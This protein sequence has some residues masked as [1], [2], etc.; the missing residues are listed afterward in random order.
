MQ[1]P[2][3][4]R[5]TYAVGLVMLLA[6]VASA[7]IP[8]IRRQATQN[9]S[10]EPTSA[11]TATPLPV[12]DVSAITFDT[13]Y[14]HP[15]GLF[16]V[17]EPS[18]WNPGPGTNNGVQEQV[19]MNNPDLESIVEAYVE[20][21]QTPLT[22][23][24]ELSS[25]FDSTFLDRSWSRYSDWKETGRKE[26]GDKLVIDFE[27]TSGPRS[28][29]ARHTAWT[30][31]KWI[32]AVRVVMPE[33]GRDALL[34]LLDK[35]IPTLQPIRKFEGTPIEWNAYFDNE[36]K[37]IIRYP[38]EWDILD[39]AQGLPASLGQGTTSLRLESDQGAVADEAAAQAWV[40]GQYGGA[41]VLSVEP[42]ERDGNKGFS[43][44][45]DYTDP[46]GE[47]MSGL[48]VLLNGPD[49]RLHVANLRFMAKGVDLNNLG[50]QPV[51]Q[52]ATL[53]QVMGT[54]TIFPD[55]N[56]QLGSVIPKS[57]GG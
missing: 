1:S 43:V 33:N 55:L 2:F 19:N 31:G 41:K 11:P 9:Q 5:I 53:A 52:Y 14:L 51:A 18:G 29:L 21:P 17:A 34:F 6:M 22:T 27:L 15:S 48:S 16:T 35:L 32:Y 36:T 26:D 42:V 13:T 24:D 50:E 57:Q 44:A 23:V 8:F 54:F 47:S 4:K 45:Y 37:H 56:A 28:Y 39:Y 7:F 38:P 3:A 30:D 49:S 46:D 20:I 10:V 40:E 12:P 25:H